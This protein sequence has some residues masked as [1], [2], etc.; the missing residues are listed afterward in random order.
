M[1]AGK[2]HR[3]GRE[4]SQAHNLGYSRTGR[5]HVRLVRMM[6]APHLPPLQ[7]RFRTLTSSYYRGAQGVILGAE[8][9]IPFH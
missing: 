8:T 1:R 3:R 7:E 5:Y 4:E 6:H 2:S 9:R